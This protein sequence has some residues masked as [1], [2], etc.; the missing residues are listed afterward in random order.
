MK[1]MINSLRCIERKQNESIS[2]IV[3]FCCIILYI[4]VIIRLN[5]NISLTNKYVQGND[6]AEEPS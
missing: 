1:G 3:Y 2:L 6:I 4:G 5:F